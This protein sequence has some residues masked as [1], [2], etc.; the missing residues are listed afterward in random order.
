MLSWLAWLPFSIF[1]NVFGVLA[2]PVAL[3]SF[4]TYLLPILCQ[5]LYSFLG[6]QNLKAKY[7]AK[8]ALVTGG[9]SGIGK[10]LCENLLGQGINVI[11][12]ALETER[13]QPTL[14]NAVDEFRKAY[15]NREV[16]V[17]D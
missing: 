16:C 3:L 11:V 7:N 1:W 14:K 5:M 8:W 15:P 9:S 12:A 17:R 6:P 13:G 10:A 4:V 2:F